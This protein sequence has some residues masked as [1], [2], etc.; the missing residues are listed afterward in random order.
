MKQLQYK[1]RY[2]DCEKDPFYADGMQMSLSVIKGIRTL[3][4]VEPL[5]NICYD[6]TN[7]VGRSLNEK[8]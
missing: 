5:L 2:N 4:H 3:T 8:S 6:I 7:M 1:I